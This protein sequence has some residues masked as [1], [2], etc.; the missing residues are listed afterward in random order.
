MGQFT[1]A[2]S[3][4][5]RGLRYETA[6]GTKTLTEGRSCYDIGSSSPDGRLQ[7]AMDH[8][9]REGQK[10]GIDGDLLVNVRIKRQVEHKVETTEKSS[11]GGL[12]DD[13][14]TEQNVDHQECWIV[15]GDLVK[16]VE[17]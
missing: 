4:N 12:V 10:K 7:E 1:A 16:I 9:I 14:K 6:S 17:K 15:T 3:F 11:W 5:I 8:A 13:G 2:S